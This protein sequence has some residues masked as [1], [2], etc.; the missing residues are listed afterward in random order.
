[1]D[2]LLK[3]LIL[4]SHSAAILGVLGFCFLTIKRLRQKGTHLLVAGASIYLVFSNG[5]VA[6]GLIGPLEYRYPPLLNS[7]EA[8]GV[9]TAV[10]LT[11][12]ASDDQSM[13][14]SSRAG[15]S[16]AYRVLEASRLFAVTNWR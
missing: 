9:H 12:F 10:V 2:E 6:A 4:P 16:A 11:S 13:P 1:M 15:Q 3:A 14:L 7:D 8:P 5:I